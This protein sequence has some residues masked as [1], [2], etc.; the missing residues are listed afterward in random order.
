MQSLRRYRER[1]L[2]AACLSLPLAALGF[3]AV[4]GVTR[5]GS[6]VSLTLSLERDGQTEALDVDARL[7]EDGTTLTGVTRHDRFPEMTF[8]VTREK[9]REDS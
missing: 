6:E 2:I 7:S 1:L 3:V 4:D 8:T 9:P 5:D